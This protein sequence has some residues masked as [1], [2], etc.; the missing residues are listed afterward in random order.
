MH[1]SI[2]FFIDNLLKNKYMNYCSGMVRN[3]NC[4]SVSVCPAGPGRPR[5]PLAGTKPLGTCDQNGLA[6]ALASET[7]RTRSLAL[8]VSLSERGV[9]PGLSCGRRAP[10]SGGWGGQSPGTGTGR[11]PLARCDSGAG[12]GAL[13]GAS[14]QDGDTGQATSLG[15][16]G[17]LLLLP[18]LGRPPSASIAPQPP[19]PRRLRAKGEGE[20]GPT[21]ETGGSGTGSLLWAD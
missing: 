6:A 14:G 15:G 5:E 3:P 16:S 13:R 4:A 9:R 2:K 7:A 17:E 10:W 12:R 1:F 18:G 21:A 11:E 19:T 20:N 8:S